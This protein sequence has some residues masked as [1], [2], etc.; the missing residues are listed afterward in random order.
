MDNFWMTLGYALDALNYVPEAI[1]EHMHYLNGKANQDAGY[2]EVN[3]SD[4]YTHDRQVFEEY[5][6]N[7]LKDD[8]L[9]VAASLL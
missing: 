8:V 7:Q 1:I 5:A 9:K 3:S 4:V 2:S 6:A